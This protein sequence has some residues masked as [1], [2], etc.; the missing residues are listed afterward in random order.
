MFRTVFLSIIRSPRLNIQRQVYVIQVRWLFA[1]GP[2]NK[3]STNLYVK[4]LTP[5]NRRKDPPKHVECYSVNSKNCASSSFCYRNITV[6]CLTVQFD[7]TSMSYS[8][9]AFRPCIMRLTKSGRTIRM[10][11]NIEELKTRR[12]RLREKI[13]KG[14]GALWGTTLIIIAEGGHSEKLVALKVARQCPLVLPINV[15]WWQGKQTHYRPGQALRV[16]GS[17]GSQIS[18][19]SALVGDKVVSLTH[20]PPLS[21][22]NIPGTHFC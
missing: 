18:R 20:R 17:W 4:S 7:C 13:K 11:R 8:Q 22:G 5:D 15:G 1:S 6:L 19:Q 3:Q 12:E 10:K 16:P 9:S 21:P 2:A 14:G